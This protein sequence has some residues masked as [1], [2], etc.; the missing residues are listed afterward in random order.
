MKTKIQ[1]K[2]KFNFQLVL[3]RDRVRVVFKIDLRTFFESNIFYQSLKSTN[4]GCEV[5]NSIT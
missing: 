2:E 5:K 4:R 3:R 1:S